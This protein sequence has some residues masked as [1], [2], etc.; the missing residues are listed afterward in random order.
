VHIR[1]RGPALSLIL[2]SEKTQMTHHDFDPRAAR[3]RGVLA[4]HPGV[5]CT[6][7]PVAAGLDV[8]VA[9]VEAGLR[10]LQA[11]NLVTALGAGRYRLSSVLRA[12]DNGL[13]DAE[14]REAQRR[15]L[16]WYLI[17][18][19]AADLA[20][21]PLPHRISPVYNTLDPFTAPY[22][23][24]DA[25]EALA[26]FTDEHPNVM[27]AQQRAVGNEWDQ[28]VYQFAETLWNPLRI[29]YRS[30][31]LAVSQRLGA[32]AAARCGHVLEPFCRAR[33]ASA[34]SRR[35]R[36]AIALAVS[37]SA[38]NRATTLGNRR[39]L[40]DAL[41]VRSRAARQAGRLVDAQLD[42]QRALELD[43]EGGVRR[44]Q[45]LR[46][47]EFGEI[48][49]D[50][51]VADPR[52]ALEHFDSATHLFR[53]LGDDVGHAKAMI[54]KARALAQLSMSGAALTALDDIEDVLRSYGAPGCLGD[55]AG[56]RA[57]IHARRGDHDTAHHYYCAAVEHFTAAGPGAAAT[58]RA[59][60][61]LRDGVVKTP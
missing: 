27:A 6:A 36:H 55:L 14:R 34:E 11:E 57:E 49:L 8:P 12:D 4:A 15:M 60:T 21:N 52:L 5:E 29:T 17:R 1:W 32:D 47:R 42:Q 9:E 25:A 23:F 56:A 13:P 48:A 38:V 39:A 59:L 35:G 43:V 46:L 50:S 19:A 18:T 44:G 26:W 7:S 53:T 24:A 40:A 20:L 22:A 51:A 41:A 37:T 33:Q 31:D 16:Q 2:H 10:L 54:G 58:V 28:L 61:P 30:D 3:L 45:A